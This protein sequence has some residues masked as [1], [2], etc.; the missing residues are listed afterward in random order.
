MGEATPKQDIKIGSKEMVLWRDLKDN[1]KNQIEQLE[2]GLVVNKA[3]L[4]MAEKKY[5]EEEERW[6][7][8]EKK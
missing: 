7:K 1:T 6:N 8:K 4:S 2:K 3:I 5:K